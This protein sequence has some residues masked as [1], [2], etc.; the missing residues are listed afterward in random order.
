MFLRRKNLLRKNLLRKNLLRKNNME[1]LFV[2]FNFSDKLKGFSCFVVT[3]SL[4]AKDVFIFSPFKP[5]LSLFQGFQLAVDPSFIGA[6]L[7][8]CSFMEQK[9][10]FLRF[11]GTIKFSEKILTPVGLARE[12]EVILYWFSEVL[13]YQLRTMLFAPSKKSMF[14]GLTLSNFQLK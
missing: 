11:N 10:R 8:S 13:N 7:P 2:L 1:R 6:V 5:V 4:Q 9:A 12:S 3:Y 14:E